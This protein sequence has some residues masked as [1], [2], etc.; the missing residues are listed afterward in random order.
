MD[1]GFQPLFQHQRLVTYQIAI[2]PYQS[3]DGSVCIFPLLVISS[4]QNT[5]VQSLFCP[6][7][8]KTMKKQVC[9]SKASIHVFAHL[10][11]LSS[12]NSTLAY[13][14]LYLPFLFFSPLSPPSASLI[15]PSGSNLILHQIL[16]V[17]EKVC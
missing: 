5:C 14:L 4:G 16:M 7:S 13:L 12:Q 11:L 6:S 17:K 9:S 1:N 2:C 15:I 10:F 3:V 8:F